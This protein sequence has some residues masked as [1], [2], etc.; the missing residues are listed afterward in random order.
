MSGNFFEALHQIATEKGIPREV[1]ED[2]VESAM[3]SAYRKQ[4]GTSNNVKVVFD[5]STN[6]IMLVTT[7][8]V[9][10]KPRNLAEEIAIDR[11]RKIHPDVKLGDEIE[12]R[13][14]PLETFGRIAAQT[15]KQV[16]MQ[17]IKE[18]EKDIVYNEFKS[19]ENEFVNGY[20]Q[21]KTK[22]KIF[23][24]LGKTEGIL[25]LKEQSPLEH[26]KVGDRIKAIVLSV[27]KDSKGPTIILS[28]SHP[29]F[30]K[31]L[32]EMEIP[33]VYDGV[34]KIVNIVRFTGVR[35]KVAVT[36]DRDDVD[37]V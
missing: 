36:S 32:F 8:M 26:Y 15:A 33:E 28:R 27:T 22:D 18:A 34:V 2:I 1:I 19:K 14:N 20:V 24:D 35:T 3:L 25:P 5:R 12:V 4:Y 17:R 16:M 23:V 6:S 29:S 7:K 11:A 21:R 10:N 31:K 13:E 30:I 9:V 37:S